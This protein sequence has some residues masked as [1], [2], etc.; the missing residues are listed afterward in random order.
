MDAI[1]ISLT[2]DY[3]D[4]N[5]FSTLQMK[6]VKTILIMCCDRLMERVEEGMCD[7]SRCNFFVF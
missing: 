7:F 2:S 4:Q 1:Y 5:D 6:N 3:G